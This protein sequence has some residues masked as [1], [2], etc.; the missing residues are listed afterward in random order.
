VL[1]MF[2]FRF[3]GF[4]MLEYYGLMFAVSIV[5]NC[6]YLAVFPAELIGSFYHLT[7]VTLRLISFHGYIRAQAR[8][9][10]LPI[11]WASEAFLSFF[12]FH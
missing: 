10:L 5:A 9:I 7:V 11:L 4:W 1:H 3:F 8:H 2:T 6:G 12:F